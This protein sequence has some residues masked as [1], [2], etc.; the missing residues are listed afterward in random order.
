MRIEIERPRPTPSTH[1]ALVHDVEA[2]LRKLVLGLVEVLTVVVCL[3]G[4]AVP[5]GGLVRELPAPARALL[6]DA[7]LM[8][9][10]AMAGPP[11]T[12]ETA[13]LVAAFEGALPPEQRAT[14]PRDP[15]LDRAAAVLAESYT[16]TYQNTTHALTQWVLQRSGSVALDASPNVS[17]GTRRRPDAFDE[18]AAVAAHRLGGSG[19]PRAF[20][21]AR[22]TEGNITSQ[23][24]VVANAPL[25]VKS[26]P[27]TYAPGGVLTLDVRPRAAFT[28]L[29]LY[30]DNDA[31]T[32]DVQR[33]E[34]RP[35]GRFFVSRTVPSHPGRYF[36]EIRGTEP[37]SMNPRQ[38]AA[39][40]LLLVPIY[41]GVPE[42]SEPEAFIRN[43]PSTPTDPAA[44]PAWIIAMYDAQRAR[45]RKPP[46]LANARLTA[47]AKRR[48]MAVAGMLSG[49]SSERDF[50]KSLAATGLSVREHYWGTEH[51]DTLADFVYLHLLSPARRRYLVLSDHATH[52]IGIVPEPPDERGRVRYA[53]AEYTVL[54]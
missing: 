51:F 26:F 42:P 31:G 3:V 25:A 50:R 18:F 40:A 46:L 2:G 49:P 54:E 43:P 1:D 20:G 27:K 11:A 21:V 28:D 47:L 23:A 34:P 53:V 35:D 44:W 30:A 15:A 39:D 37:A 10:P 7:P 29:V 17:G 24:I 41:V 36:I 16:E 38:R 12:V 33:M 45:W 6:A 22:L 48:A 19:F 5:R 9:A 13:T 4:C 8:Y 52:A 32:V 14:M